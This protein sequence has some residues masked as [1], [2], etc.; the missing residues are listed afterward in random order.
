M[1]TLNNNLST[2]YVTYYIGNPGDIQRSTRIR[3]FYKKNYTPTLS[4]IMEVHDN[5]MKDSEF[6]ESGFNNIITRETP[7]DYF[8]I[9]SEEGGELFG[10]IIYYISSSPLPVGFTNFSRDQSLIIDKKSKINSIKL[11]T[12]F[13]VNNLSVDGENSLIVNSLEELRA[14]KDSDSIVSFK[15]LENSEDLK[16]YSSTK[17]VLDYYKKTSS[18]GLNYKRY[19]SSLLDLISDSTFT[20]M[21][22]CLSVSGIKPESGEPFKYSFSLSNGVEINTYDVVY[23]KFFVGTYKNEISL[24]EWSDDEKTR[25]VF[26]IISLVR[27]NKFGLPRILKEKTR[28]EDLDE[29]LEVIVMSGDYIIF[30]NKN[31]EEHYISNITDSILKISKISSDYGIVLDSWGNNEI[32]YYKKNESFILDVFPKESLLYQ[33]FLSLPINRGLY[34]SLVFVK[35]D[36]GWFVF[37]TTGGN[38]KNSKKEA[39]IYSSPYGSIYFDSSEENEIIPVNN[40]IILHQTKLDSGDYKF[41]FYFVKPESP[42]YSDNYSK[43]NGFGLEFNNKFEFTSSINST[44]STENIRK[45]KVLIDGLRHAPLISYNFPAARKFISSYMG[46]LFYLEEIDGFQKIFYL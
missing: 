10:T 46:I 31:T 3:L 43:N 15:R 36:S 1:E 12:S 44:D 5:I 20:L 41:S 27:K 2:N 29:N 25:G 45:R 33:E 28:F 37:K 39:L 30:K 22:D 18:S 4:N 35:K 40:K 42:V 13:N 24:F 17:S 6:N 14:F 23:T 26:R 9:K 7:E 21:T 34:S 38:G 32:Q 11:Y 16:H 8:E 19:T